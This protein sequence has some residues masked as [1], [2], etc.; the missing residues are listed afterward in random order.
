[1][2]RKDQDR[3]TDRDLDAALKNYGAVEPRRGLESRIIA[4]LRTE[5]ARVT[6]PAWRWWPALA[7]V[8]S[9]L[10][11]GT[12]VV[13]KTHHSTPP[14]A[15]G[16][17]PAVPAARGVVTSH[18]N[19]SHVLTALRP[20]RRK[21]TIVAS[22]PRLE[23][24]PSPQPLSEQEQLLARYIKQFPRQATLMARAQ[25]EL[26]KQEMMERDVPLGDAVS[27]DPPQQ[28]D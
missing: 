25:T 15:V 19:E 11:I 21:G 7:V 8:T 12:A 28:Q 5:R 22:A 4:N 2:E 9:I 6:T 26:M 3:F 10:L 23:Q 24:F 1:M 18:G 13:L 16:N 20:P 14:V 17:Q 27:T